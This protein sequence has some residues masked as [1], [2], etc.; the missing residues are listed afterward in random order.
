MGD[1]A[2]R[3]LTSV[4]LDVHQDSIDVAVA[5]RDGAVR[6]LGAIVNIPPPRADE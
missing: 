1:T 5:Q 4:G 2:T 3:A 6:H